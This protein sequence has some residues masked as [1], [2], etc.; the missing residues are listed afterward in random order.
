MEADPQRGFGGPTA[1][2]HGGY[3]VSRSYL[4]RLRLRQFH[5]F[6][7]AK[8][9]ALRR[10]Q[11]CLTGRGKVPIGRGDQSAG[12][13]K[14][15][16]CVAVECCQLTLGLLGTPIDAEGGQVSVFLVSPGLGFLQQFASLRMPQRAEDDE[17]LPLLGR[18][19]VHRRIVV[20]RAGR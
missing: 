8:H 10:N 18:F 12:I 5:G 19:P 14:E 2:R 20:Q 17:C 13:G 7:S 4:S 3:D 11:E 15:D 9:L 1:V 6:R 16:F